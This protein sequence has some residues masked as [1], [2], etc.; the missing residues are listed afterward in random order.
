M[1]F[2]GIR[3]ADSKSKGLFN[4]HR[5]P[6]PRLLTITSFKR[7]YSCISYLALFIRFLRA[8]DNKNE[9]IR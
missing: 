3:Q 9:F 1:E 7:F 2:C 8:K 5:L 6:S 4:M